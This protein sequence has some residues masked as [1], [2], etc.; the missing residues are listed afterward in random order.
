MRFGNFSQFLNRCTPTNTQIVINCAN[1]RSFEIADFQSISTGFT[2]KLERFN[3]GGS[4]IRAIKIY[5]YAATTATVVCI[6]SA[7]FQ[8]TCCS[9]A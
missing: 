9:A 2:T 6:S 1:G 7:S 3:S 4:Q 5:I 8:I